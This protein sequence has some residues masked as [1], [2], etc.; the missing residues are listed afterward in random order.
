MNAIFGGPWNIAIILVLPVVIIGLAKSL[1]KFNQKIVDKKP[2][3][4][5]S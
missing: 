5:E 4:V 2:V 1:K 3:E